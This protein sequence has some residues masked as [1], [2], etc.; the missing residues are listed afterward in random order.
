METYHC[1]EV[2]FASFLSGGFNT[3]I[4]VNPPKRKQAKRTSVH[5]FHNLKLKPFTREENQRT[6]R[7]RTFV[8]IIPLKAKFFNL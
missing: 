7:L 2:R 8:P 3:A 1:T 5:W 6:L 4:L